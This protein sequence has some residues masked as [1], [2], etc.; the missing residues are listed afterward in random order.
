MKNIKVKVLTDEKM[1]EINSRRRS[2]LE[3]AKE[4]GILY[5]KLKKVEENLSD[6]ELIEEIKS[7]GTLAGKLIEVLSVISINEKLG[8]NTAYMMR[9]RSAIENKP[10]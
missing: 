9:I 4:R 5:N 6:G 10:L 7:V 2:L 3:E 8:Q 1:N